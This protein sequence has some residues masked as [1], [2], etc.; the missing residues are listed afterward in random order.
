MP[1]SFKFDLK[2]D[3]LVCMKSAMECQKL[4]TIDMFLKH[5]LCLHKARFGIAWIHFLITGCI[6]MIA[7]MLVFFYQN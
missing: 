5:I 2:F 6:L 7:V 1:F 4:G 3:P